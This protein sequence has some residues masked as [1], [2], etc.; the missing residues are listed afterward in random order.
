MNKLFSILTFFV[1]FSATSFADTE[2]VVRPGDTVLRIADR[3]LRI[4]DRSDPRRFDFAKKIL[5]Q[6]PQIKNK[7]ALEIGDKITIP[8]TGERA[9]AS[10]APEKAPAPE[11]IVEEKAVPEKVEESMAP[12]AVVPEVKK[13][14]L[15]EE[16]K[17]NAPKEVEPAKAHG[18]D[19]EIEPSD[20]FA[21]EPRYVFNSYKVKD[22]QADKDL[23]LYSKVNAGIGF[24]YGK[25]LTHDLVLLFEA[26]AQYTQMRSLHDPQGD[27]VEQSQWLKDFA[28]GVEYEIV[29]SLSVEAKA[30]LADH[31]FILP[32]GGMEYA[33]EGV[34]IPGGEIALNWAFLQQRSFFIGIGVGAEYAGW[35]SKSGRT[36]KSVIDPAASLYWQTRRGEHKTNY[37]LAAT[38]SASG[39]SSDVTDQ[40]GTNIGA[41]FSFV[42]PL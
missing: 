37:R 27:L 15:E 10:E 6:N 17:V 13:V 20:F 32:R 1:A 29:Y 11:E 31:L 14:V 38:Y 35:A 18:S 3:A 36:Y 26:G 5:A 2:Y 9:V 41:N 12:E 22:K 16:P 42:F 8:A 28:I 33:V 24:T 19:R 34:L 25:M 30:T 40:D 23:N 39:Q 7:N 21:V 4:T